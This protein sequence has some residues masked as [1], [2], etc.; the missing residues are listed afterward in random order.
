MPLPDDI[1]ANLPPPRDDEP[2]S[3][4]RDICD[5]LADH[6]ACAL[7]RERQRQAARPDE[8]ASLPGERVL[9]RF[10][11]PAQVAMRLWWDAMWEK[12]M[13]QRIL[14]ACTGM[15]TVACC[16][17]VG[18]AFQMVRQQQRAMDQ[19]VA[20]MAAEAQAKEEQRRQLERTLADNREA[21]EKLI[22]QAE[23]GAKLAQQ[24]L[25]E[26]RI[27]QQDLVSRLKELETKAAAPAD[28]NPAD[29][30]LVSGADDG[31]PAVGIEVQMTIQADGAGVPPLSGKSD[32]KGVV[33]FERVR[34]GVY[35]MT[36]TAPWGER[37]VKSLGLQPGEALREKIIC[38]PQAPEPYNGIVQLDLPGDLRERPI[39]FSLNNS[40]A[41]RVYGKGRWSMRSL[42]TTRGGGFG[43]GFGG[44]G[45]ILSSRGVVHA[46]DR[47][48]ASF[49]RELLKLGED[50]KVLGI[51][52][53][54]LDYVPG[55]AVSFY[56]PSDVDPAPMS[57][58]EARSQRM[59]AVIPDAELSADS[60]KFRRSPE[61]T[62]LVVLP[63]AT[64][65]ALRAAFVDVD[66][67]REAGLKRISFSRQ[68]ALGM[69]VMPPVLETLQ[70]NLEGGPFGQER[71]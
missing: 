25:A 30:E 32:A 5:E 21:N 1:A 13:T 69:T 6:L 61:G 48:P 34:Y 26:A 18:A 41:F 19:V 65:T 24:G 57:G 27:A 17:A 70:E 51:R 44:T 20:A 16:V 64:V 38:P 52:Y 36:C 31:P 4:R 53:P 22:A 54:G 58:E 66:K 55:S 2:A 8:S 11:N 45:L 12:V 23:A 9:Q 43:T 47:R 62:L 35:R 7:D 42:P 49:I 63:E 71:R 56:T 10:G 39:Y 60:V 46:S 59:L 28:W 14:V 67:T 50:G 37:S 29:F 33:R 40:T 15:L 3:L 68:G